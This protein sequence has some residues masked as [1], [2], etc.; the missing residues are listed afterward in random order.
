MRVGQ[1]VTLKVM[2]HSG[3]IKAQ[4]NKSKTLRCEVVKEYPYFYLMEHDG[5]KECFLKT[6]FITKDIQILKV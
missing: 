4:G 1:K 3:Y 5:I 6:D 2:G